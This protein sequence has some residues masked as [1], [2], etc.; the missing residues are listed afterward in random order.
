MRNEQHKRG[1]SQFPMSS[2]KPYVLGCVGPL[3]LLVEVFFLRAIVLRGRGGLFS[4]VK[5]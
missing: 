3:P 2:S 1:A 5:W 4:P